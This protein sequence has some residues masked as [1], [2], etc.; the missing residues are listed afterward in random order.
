[1]SGRGVAARR[2]FGW[3]LKVGVGMV[4][5]DVGKNQEY[6]EKGGRG[7]SGTQAWVLTRSGLGL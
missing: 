2:G 7:R 6:A 3:S 5:H 1:M 4:P